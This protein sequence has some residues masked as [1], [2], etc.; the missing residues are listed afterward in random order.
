MIQREVPLKSLR[1]EIIP[2]S[3]FGLIC[4]REVPLELASPKTLASSELEFVH[5]TVQDNSIHFYRNCVCI[6]LFNIRV[7][8]GVDTAAFSFSSP[9]L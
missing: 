2:A 8:V 5:S 3:I 7:V 1:V 9:P 4:S 6:F